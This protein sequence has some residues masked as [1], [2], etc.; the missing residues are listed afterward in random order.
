MAQKLLKAKKAKIAPKKDAV[1]ETSIV[2]VGTYKERQLAWIRKNGV[3]NY[4]VREGDELTD[5]ACGKVKELWLYADAKGTRH[6]FAAEFMSKMSREEFLAAYPT[7]AKLPAHSTNAAKTKMHEVPPLVKSG[8]RAYYVFK[9]TASLDYG[10]AADG[11]VV[12]AR[13]ADFGGRSAKVKKAVE[14]F[15]ADGEFA[16]LVAYLPPD[17]AKVQKGQ[18]RVCEAAVQ[19]DFI[20]MIEKAMIM[21]HVGGTRN[22]V[23]LFSGAGG[24]DLGFERAGFSI[25]WAN[26]YDKDIWETYE[27]NHK[28][29]HLCRKSICEVDASEVPDCVGIIGGPPC[30]SWSE[31][32]A[33]RGIDD[34]RGQLFFDYIRILKAKRPLFFLAENVSG[35]LL[36]RHRDALAE[37][38]RQFSEAGY[39]L[40]FTPVN[41]WEYGVPHVDI[42]GNFVSVKE[43][44][45]D[46]RQMS[47]LECYAD[48]A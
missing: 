38:K 23:S 39:R 21:K 42:L 35:M 48:A 9:I 16:P 15:K 11:S 27:K 29:T 18:L 36:E 12:V 41:A 28:K 14:R 32:G 13:A 30:Q 2:L 20:A 31:G 47:L 6:A 19:M 10:P 3:Y 26:E 34:K 40:S 25:V 44:I 45:C 33:K 17:L 43:V 37:I 7:Y 5:E 4:P 46:L 8:N 22:I 24:L 1:K